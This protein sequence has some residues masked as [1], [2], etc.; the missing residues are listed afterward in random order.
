M[1][2]QDEEIRQ[3]SK[4]NDASFSI[5]RIRHWDNV[6]FKQNDTLDTFLKN[7]RGLGLYYNPGIDIISKKV[8][9]PSE[10]IKDTLDRLSEKDKEI[11]EDFELEDLE[12][13]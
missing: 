8:S 10:E 7:I 11:L 5:S 3:I 6:R 1:D 9:K 2:F 13:G 12:N 4:Y